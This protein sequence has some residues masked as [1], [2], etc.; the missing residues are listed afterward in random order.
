[1]SDI[2]KRLASLSPE[3]R[4]LLIK[5]LQAKGART[6]Q[7]SGLPPIERRPRGDAPLPLSFA[8]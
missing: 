6:P 7:V 2:L 5:Q 4:D 8:Q 3:K 1:M